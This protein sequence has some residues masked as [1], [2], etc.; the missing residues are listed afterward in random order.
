VEEVQKELSE[1]TRP[2]MFLA[3][4][5]HAMGVVSFE[6]LGNPMKLRTTPSSENGRGAKT[7]WGGG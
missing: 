1:K 4:M 7:P 2:I 3:P 6:N 5:A